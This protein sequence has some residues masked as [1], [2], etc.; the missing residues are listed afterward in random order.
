MT[1]QSTATVWAERV[2][3]WRES[4][5]TAAEFSAGRGF[6]AGT[7]RMWASRLQGAEVAPAA[8]PAHGGSAAAALKAPALARVVR[9]GAP[10]M[11][12]SVAG[13]RAAVEVLVGDVRVRVERDADET[14][15]RVVLR[16]LGVAR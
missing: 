4:G 7:L 14:A 3:A 10:A 2:R 5:Q 12:A 15:L 1:D 16:A 11:P 13:P 9:A 6:A 8:S